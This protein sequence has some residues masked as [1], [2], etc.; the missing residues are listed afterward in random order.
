MIQ[1]ESGSSTSACIAE[2]A[3]LSALPDIKHNRNPSF[4]VRILDLSSN[5][6]EVLRPL[7][8]LLDYPAK[9]GL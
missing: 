2:T 9:R 4:C 7:Q 8:G 5:V 3:T 1:M 6:G